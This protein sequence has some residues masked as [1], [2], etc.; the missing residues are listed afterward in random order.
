MPAAVAAPFDS[1]I[2]H[3]GT[4]ALSITT[5]TKG[6][7]QIAGQHITKGLGRLRDHVFKEG[8]GLRVLTSVSEFLI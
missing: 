4:K 5:D 7:Q 2:P 8:K 1:H 6:L 3:N